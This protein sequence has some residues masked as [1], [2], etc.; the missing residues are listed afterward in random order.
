MRS[1][2]VSDKYVNKKVEYVIKSEFPNMPVNAMYKAF[3]KKDIKVNGVRVKEG[4][5]VYPGYKIEVYISD[6]I[7]DGAPQEIKTELNKGFTVVFEDNNLLIVNK[8]QGIPVHPDREQQNNTLIDNI[9]NYLELTGQYEP[10]NKASFTPSLCHR[11]DR[12][13]GGLVIIA[14]NEET[15]KTVLEKIKNKE[16]KKY[17]Q[18]LVQ[19]HLEKKS[20]TLKA[21][22]EKDEKKS[23][24]FIREQKSKNSLEVITKYKVLAY[25]A[26]Y[27]KLEVE[28]VTGRTHQIRAHFAHIGHPVVGDGKYGTNQFNRAMGVKFQALWAYKLHFDFVGISNLNYIKGRVFQVEP[29]FK[30][31][32]SK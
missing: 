12:N 8:E 7:L 32:R 26:D 22:L 27:T 29:E 20:D 23:R 18:C 4:Y 28:L 30:L 6:N 10:K 1:I 24:V 25:E 13:T 31:N 21:Y 17:Y 3:R 2:T 11:L 5:P 19:G 16:I 15:L 14:K 9:K